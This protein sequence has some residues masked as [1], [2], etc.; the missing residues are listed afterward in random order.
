MKVKDL[1][2][3]YL[4][5]DSFKERRKSLEEYLDSIG[6]KF[7]RIPS[8]STAN[9]RQVRIDEGFIKLA[10][11]AIENNVY[12][13]LVLED[14][15][16]LITPLPEDITIPEDCMFI[17]WGISTWECGGLKSKLYI[18]NYNDEYYRMYHSLGC[19]AII[20]PNKNSAEHFI[21]IN[22]KAIEKKDFSDIY[23]AVDSG[24]E[25]YLTPKDGPYFYQHDGHTMPI[26]KF[27]WK[28]KL[29]YLK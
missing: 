10:E 9:L 28:D 17:Y 1:Q 19:H 23:F 5:P 2:V 16:R 13:F 11:R 25:V 24:K 6:L 4:N 8:N 22:Q 12:P 21:A 20:V 27:L 18:T 29:N 15:A 3:Y 7:E 14:D 26:T